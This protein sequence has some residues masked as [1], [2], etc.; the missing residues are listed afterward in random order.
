M[1]RLGRGPW[2]GRGVVAEPLGLERDLVEVR[3]ELSD[4]EP[5]GIDAVEVVADQAQ[6]QVRAS[7]VAQH[8]A[9]AVQGVPDPREA[10]VQSS[11]R[12]MSRQPSPFFSSRDVGGG[13]LLLGA[14]GWLPSARST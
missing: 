10:L 6:E 3:A 14:W 8:E 2:A 11:S 9:T 13:W 5:L 1:T 12:V 7:L 4:V